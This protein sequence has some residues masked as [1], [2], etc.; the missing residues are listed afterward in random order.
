MSTPRYDWWSY[1]KGMIRRYPELCRREAD[2]HTTAVTPNYGG[3]PGGHGGRSDPVA[4]AALRSLPEVNRRKGLRWAVLHTAAEAAAWNAGELDVLLAQP[5]SCAYGLN[6]QAGG[7]HLIWYTLPWSLELYA[8]GE[9]R[10][11]RQ[12]QTQPV[13]VHRL[14]VKGG[15]DELVAKALTRKNGG[16]AALLDAVK[17]KIQEEHE[18]E[19]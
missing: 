12:G 18:T 17:A 6:L 19:G 11:Y 7:H 10:L 1:V 5:A 9:A 13:I 14:L 16:Q 15:A 8:Q 2:L 4:N 3:A